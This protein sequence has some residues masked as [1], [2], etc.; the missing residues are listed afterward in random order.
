MIIKT[1][2]Q[3]AVIALIDMA[4]N[5]D[6]FPIT[7]ESINE[8]TGIS[9]SYLE[10]LFGNM[11]RRGIVTSVRGPG[12]GYHLAVPPEKIIVSEVVKAVDSKNEAETTPAFAGAIKAAMDYLASLTLADITKEAENAG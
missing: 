6:G 1:K 8:R 9:T 3:M 11:R 12:G 2:G 5:Q 7:L 4:K 10:Q